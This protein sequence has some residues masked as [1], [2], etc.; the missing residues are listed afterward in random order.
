MKAYPLYPER[1]SEILDGFW[2]F[3]WMGDNIA[4]DNIQPAAL[5]YNELMAVPGVFDTGID[6]FGMRG[7]GVY[8]R[9]ISSIATSDA[10]LRLKIG[11]MGLYGRIWWNGREIGKYNLPY[12]GVDYDFVTGNETEHEL[13]IAV[14]NRFDKARTP[15]F[16]PEFDFYGYGGIY[17]SIELQQLPECYLER[18]QVT[19]L[20]ITSGRVRL[21]LRLGGKVP[22][23]LNFTVAF[24]SN[25]AESFQKKITN[26]EIESEQTVPDFKIWSPAS[27]GLHTVTVTIAG[28]SIVERFGIRTVEAR[29][30]KI[31]LNGESVRLLG[32][33]R[34]ESHPEFGPVQPPHLMIDDLRL[35]KDLGC[36]FVRCVHYPQDQTF[37]DLCDQMGMLVWQE[38]LGGF[39]SPAAPGHFEDQT[40]GHTESE[41]RDQHFL[42]LQVRQTAL[43]VQHSINHPSVILWGFLNEG[44]SDTAGGKALYGTLAGTIRKEDPSLLVTFASNKHERDIC[45]EYADV[46]AMNLYPGWIDG[47]KDWTTPSS[48]W[49]ENFINE[50]AKI[51]ERSEL[52]EKPLLVTEIGACALYGC[53]DR[54]NAQWSEE[55][56]ADYFKEACR[57]ILK[58]S[59]FAG[60]ALWQMFDTR[61]FVNAGQVRAKPRGFNCAGL[62]DEYRRPKLAY[63]AVKKIFNDFWRGNSR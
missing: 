31:L 44:C 55:F 25:K 49:I 46:I 38:S 4:I 58:N 10:T 20:D 12:S 32:V 9:K 23:E 13:V 2:D 52:K 19:T 3:C 7:V 16:L 30:Q 8:R 39:A 5:V 26:G 36:N 14:D 43:M 53:H 37:L 60:V 41:A 50:K 1:H 22:D 27:P 15:L 24:D 11:G 57:C 42:E 35:L 47:I 59:R 6:R 54:A 56:Q 17:R 62:L 28:D 18:V 45:L 51:A 40:W 21:R 29:D 34:H 63:D 61:S 48:S 33:C